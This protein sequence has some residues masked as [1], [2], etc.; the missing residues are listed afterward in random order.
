MF[1]AM[2]GFLSAAVGGLIALSS[3]TTQKLR[4]MMIDQTRQQF[5]DVANLINNQI[6]ALQMQSPVPSGG[7][8]ENIATYL[9]NINKV[10]EIIDCTTGAPRDPWR[11]AITGKVVRNTQTMV[12]KNGL[13]FTVPV[14][15]YVLASNGPDGTL[16]TTIPAAPTTLANIT[17]ITPAG[18]DVIWVFTDLPGQRNN[19]QALETA[20]TNVGLAAQ[21]NYQQQFGQIRDNLPVIYASAAA[22]SGGSFDFTKPQMQNAWKIWADAAH[23]GPATTSPNYTSE[24]AAQKTYIS[25]TTGVL[26][27]S[28]GRVFAGTALNTFRLGADGDVAYIQRSLPSGGNMTLNGTVSDSN[29][30][31][32]GINDVIL[33]SVST[34]GTV[35]QQ[36]TPPVCGA[37][38]PVNCVAVKGNI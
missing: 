18:D 30:P 17:S 12:T 26:T 10:R 25:N 15:A 5:T 11:R 16:N 24:L 6:V 37:A 27:P 35:W 23:P 31:L 28:F 3:L 14:T 8:S 33:L 19:L 22:Q 21:R 29:A 4:L 38:K 32:Y 7:T 34:T 36:A 2:F 20:V 9:C 13:M 1:F